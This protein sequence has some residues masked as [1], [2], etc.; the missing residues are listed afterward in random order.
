MGPK[1]GSFWARFGTHFGLFLGPL[2]GPIL[3][4]NIRKTKPFG[5]FW[6][7][8]KAQFLAHFG[9]TFGPV[10]GSILGS[11][12]GT[13]WDAGRTPFSVVLGLAW[14][15]PKAGVRKVSPRPWLLKNF[16]KDFLKN[17]LRR[18]SRVKVF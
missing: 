1:V 11:I 15:G 2:R 13:F 17:F 16:L 3:N 5:A 18:L 10:L 12:L 14:P 4:E 8:K 7:P 9:S 6:P